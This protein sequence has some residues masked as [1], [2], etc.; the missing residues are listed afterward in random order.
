MKKYTLRRLFNDI[1]LWLGIGSGIILFIV[2]LS[3]TILTFE[4]EIIER[5]DYQKYHVNTA[6]NLP[7]LSSDI[8]VS[9]VEKELGGK[10]ISLEIPSDKG[11]AGC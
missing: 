8:L 4:H 3:G 6:G 5:I 7:V 1:H 11:N 10:V 9:K 2:C